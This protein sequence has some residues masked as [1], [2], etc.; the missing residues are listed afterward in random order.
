MSLDPYEFKAYCVFKMTAGDRGSCFK[1]MTT[2]CESIG[3]QKPK[4][5][6]IK[7]VLLEKGLISIQKRKSDK[8]GD[9]PD[10][11]SIV[12]I[13]PQNMKLMSQRYASKSSGGGN[14]ALQEGGNLGL[15]GGVIV[16]YG[17]GNPGLPKQELK[18]EDHKRTTTATTPSMSAA[19]GKPSAGVAAA[20]LPEKRQATTQASPASKPTAS[21]QPA[22]AGPPS[23][24]ES[25]HSGLKNID[26]S[27][28]EKRSI[29]RAFKSNQID[30]ALKWLSTTDQ[31]IKSIPA[32]IKWACKA[33]PELPKPRLS[34]LEMIKQ[35]FIHG[36]KYNGAE[37]YLTSEYLCF[38]RG[39]RNE[40]VKFDKYFSLMKVRDLCNSFGIIYPFDDK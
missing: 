24:V 3:C 32:A 17:G 2:L 29:T 11:I 18:E 27:E 35:H 25:I 7:R 5:I 30:H 15:R 6:D 38:E 28:D 33:M 4:L 37:C 13:W 26:I 36:N 22:I 31:V 9:M 21:K 16:D 39:T 8:G 14:S 40:F 12:D 23:A 1:S 19:M 34:N 20:V 10:L